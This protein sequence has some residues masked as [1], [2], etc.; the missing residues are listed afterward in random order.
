MLSV[1]LS[2]VGVHWFLVS[3]R[4]VDMML[5]HT[6]SWKRFRMLMK[7]HL[8]GTTHVAVRATGFGELEMLP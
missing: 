1:Q 4:Y 8:M 6:R 7:A 3:L 5:D 2:M